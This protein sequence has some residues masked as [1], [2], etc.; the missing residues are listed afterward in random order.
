MENEKDCKVIDINKQNSIDSL[1][2]EL[3][4]LTDPN[5]IHFSQEIFDEKDEIRAKILSGQII[6]E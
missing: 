3:E 6:F 1:I 5:G 4:E 2:A